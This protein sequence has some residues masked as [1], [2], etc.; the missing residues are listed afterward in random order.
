M[1]ERGRF[2]GVVRGV[3]HRTDPIDQIRRDVPTPALVPEHLLQLALER[4]VPR[5]RVAHAQMPLDLD[6]LEPNELAVEVQLDLAQNV[7]AVSR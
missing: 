2:S 1:L 5:A 4:G 3:E 7:F 6:A